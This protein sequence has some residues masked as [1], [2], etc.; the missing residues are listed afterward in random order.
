MV[1]QGFQIEACIPSIF[2]NH[3]LMSGAHNGIN[4]RRVAG[5]ETL[6]THDKTAMASGLH[7]VIFIGHAL[8]TVPL[9]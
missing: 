6:R 3:D 5:W 7:R 2:Q 4:K 1:L 9:S 8:K